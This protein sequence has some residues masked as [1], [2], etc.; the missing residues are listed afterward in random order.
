MV[1]FH[2]VRY[3]LI[4]SNVTLFLQPMVFAPMSVKGNREETV[5]D[6]FS[7]IHQDRSRPSGRKEDQEQGLNQDQEESRWRRGERNLF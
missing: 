2:F 5:W 6:K 1:K 7:V 3:N 4:K